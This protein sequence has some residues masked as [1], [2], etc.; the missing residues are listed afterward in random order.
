MKVSNTKRAFW[1]FSMIFRVPEN[2]NMLTENRPKFSVWKP[3]RTETEIQKP[4]RTETR[5]F[6]NRP[7]TSSNITLL[8]TKKY[9]Q[10]EKLRLIIL[11]L[12]K[13][14]KFLQRSCEMNEEE[15]R[16]IYEKHGK[17]ILHNIVSSCF[18]K[19]RENTPVKFQNSLRESLK[20]VLKK[21]L[22]FSQLE[23]CCLSF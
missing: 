15:S 20:I 6:A 14:E 4:N 22:P 1:R 21:I 18:A 16:F 13:E 11:F 2:R 19:T 17:N 3:N 5:K 10:G 8:P 12:R 23:K 9:N 7:T